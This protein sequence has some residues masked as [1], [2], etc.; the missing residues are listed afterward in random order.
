MAREVGLSA[1]ATWEIIL[2]QRQAPGAPPGT[3][4]AERLEDQIK[5]FK[6]NGL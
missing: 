3:A 1:L 6:K 2:A 5:V 4:G